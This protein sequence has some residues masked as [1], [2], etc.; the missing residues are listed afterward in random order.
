MNKKLKNQQNI[1]NIR[2]NIY[3]CFTEQINNYNS[4]Q[5]INKINRYNNCNYIN[6]NNLNKSKSINNA[7]KINNNYFD[8]KTETKKI[9]SNSNFN[10]DKFNNNNCNKK[11]VNQI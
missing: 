8:I 1:K 2:N 11:D 5:L 4:N 9:T 3:K 6:N 10:E 7:I